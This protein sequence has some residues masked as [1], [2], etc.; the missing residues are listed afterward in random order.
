MLILLNI[1]LVIVC[2]F[3]MIFEVIKLIKNAKIK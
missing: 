2:F 3:E 1:L